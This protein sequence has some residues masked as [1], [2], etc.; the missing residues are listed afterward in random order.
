M[1][2]GQIGK[3]LAIGLL[4]LGALTARPP[5][6]DATTTCSMTFKLSGWSA[7]YETA[8]GTGT[9]TCDNHQS[10]HVT[11][12]TKG[13]GVTFGKFKIVNGVGSFSEVGGIGELFGNY[14]TAGVDAG[15]GKAS[16]AQVLT[17]GTVSLA[18]AGK[19]TGVDL[20]FDFG[21]FT[22]KRAAKK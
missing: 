3:A 17:K 6:S 7:I 10:A 12:S 13:G 22:I 9:I 16:N 2:A 11:I 4:A 18:L 1:Q 14:A 21:K 15:A 20:G 19:G 5:R 8:H